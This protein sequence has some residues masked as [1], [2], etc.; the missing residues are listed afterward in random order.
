MND[1]AIIS[2]VERRIPFPF[3]Q[4]YTP[5]VEDIS[6]IFVYSKQEKL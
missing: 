2:L 1:T 3:H 4:V 5:F 6:S